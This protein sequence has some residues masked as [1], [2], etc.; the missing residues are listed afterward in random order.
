MSTISSGSV[1][2][3]LIGSPFILGAACLGAAYF[4]LKFG[5]KK[6]DETLNKIE[7]SNEAIKWSNKNTI[8]SPVKL[9]EEAVQIQ[10]LI[11]SDDSF[12]LM[13]KGM[14]TPQKDII[15]GVLATQNC[16][17]KYYVS[18]LL[19]RMPEKPEV[20]NQALQVGTKN[21]ALDNFAYV[22]SV[23]QDAAKASGFTFKTKILKKNDSL[24]DIIFVDSQNREL[25][26]YCKL[27]RQLNPSL[28]LDL[29]GFS[30]ST[31]EC[32][33]KMR[34]II[35]YLHAHEVPFNFKESR[36][37]QPFGVLRK[38]LSQREQGNKKKE[39]NDYLTGNQKAL[40]NK[41]RRHH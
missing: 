5:A 35:N 3:T 8:L 23:V 27:D 30:S 28:A 29:Y 21:L 31:D 32:S 11:S 20:F 41:N 15:S 7:K 18:S 6:I 36:H 12:K 1:P 19:D 33:L 38:L 26:A 17:L 25:T 39:L 24:L 10:K 37:D 2:L 13:T 34:E 16:P 4:A 40:C 22:N 14:T 9:A